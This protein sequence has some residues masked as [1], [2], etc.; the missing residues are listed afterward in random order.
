MAMPGTQPMTN[1]STA[2]LKIRQ[3][4]EVPVYSPDLLRVPSPKRFIFSEFISSVSDIQIY[5]ATSAANDFSDINIK[6]I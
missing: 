6:H 2:E 3:N 5:H 1:P 4:N